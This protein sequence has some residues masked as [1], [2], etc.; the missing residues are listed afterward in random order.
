M[1]DTQF[2]PLS[3]RSWS[4]LLSQTGLI[5]YALIFSAISGK[6]FDIRTSQEVISGSLSS[7]MAYRAVCLSGAIFILLFYSYIIV[8]YIPNCG[9]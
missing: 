4:D 3:L 5:G 8:I 6:F 1:V 2:R 7:A 9:P